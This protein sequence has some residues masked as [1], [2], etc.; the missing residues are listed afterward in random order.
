MSLQFTMFLAC[1]QV[2]DPSFGQP[3]AKPIKIHESIKSLK[4]HG[5]RG[6]QGERNAVEGHKND[7]PAY[8]G[9]KVKTVMT[10]V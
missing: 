1:I 7:L 9:S 5:E 6:I 4:I 8:Y 3:L 2:D 10:G